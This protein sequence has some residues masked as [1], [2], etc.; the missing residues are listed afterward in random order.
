MSSNPHHP[1]LWPEKI[2]Y[3]LLYRSVRD[4]CHP[5][6]HSSIPVC[7][8]SHTSLSP[9]SKSTAFIQFHYPSQAN[10]RFIQLCKIANFAIFANAAIIH[11]A[12]RQIVSFHSVS[13]L[14][15]PPHNQVYFIFSD[16]CCP[17]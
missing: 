6:L 4:A 13:T 2:K 11:N 1:F 16:T 10:V 5:T 14:A 7:H 9:S 17:I 15:K 3:D 8:A 12:P